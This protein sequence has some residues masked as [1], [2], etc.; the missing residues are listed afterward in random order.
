MSDNLTEA[1]KGFLAD[2]KLKSTET[3]LGYLSPCSVKLSNEL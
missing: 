1:P 2:L 3:T